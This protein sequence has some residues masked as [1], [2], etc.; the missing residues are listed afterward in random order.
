M[1]AVLSA[2]MSL[3]MLTLSVAVPV[4]EQ[5]ALFAQPIVENEHSPG[6]CPSG[7]DHTICAQVG[8]NIAIG[9]DGA[10]RP[11][12]RS[13]VTVAPVAGAWAHVA[14]AEDDTNRSRAPP[15]A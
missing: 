10:D 14:A 13:A 1:R 3:I 11:L 12:E 5:D 7:H 9:S 4:L 15:L 8:A 2:G 6:E